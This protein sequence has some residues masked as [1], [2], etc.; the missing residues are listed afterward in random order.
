MIATCG[1]SLPAEPRQPFSY[2]VFVWRVVLFVV[3]L[4]L[5]VWVLA[6]WSIDQSRQL[7]QERAETTTK[8]LAHVLENN[9]A[10]A[11][12]K[13]DIALL[14]VVDEAERQLAAGG[15]DASALNGLLDR[16]LSRLPEVISLR[17]TNGRGDVLYGNAVAGT[18]V[19]LADREFFI[20]QR[21]HADSGLVISPP[22]L[23]R[24][25]QQ[26]VIPISRR[27]H[28]PD[29]SFAGVVYSNVS[30]AYL[31]RIFSALMVGQ[32]GVIAMRDADLGIVLRYPAI[33]DYGKMVGSKEVSSVFQKLAQSGQTAGTYTVV[34]GYDGVERTFSYRRLTSHPYYVVIGLATDEYLLGWWQQTV[35]WLIHLGLFLVITL[36]AAWLLYRAWERQAVYHANLCLEVEK[37]IHSEQ[38]LQTLNKELDQRVVAQTLELRA[39]NN[40]LQSASYAAAHNLRTPLRAVNGFAGSLLEDCATLLPAEG[41]ESLRLVVTSARE[42]EETVEGFLR[43]VRATSAGISRQRV[44]LS[45]L[46]HVV[47]DRLQA[48]DPQRH[49]ILEIASA[50][51]V[52]GDP[53]L[54]QT[55]MAVL[56]DNAW[57]F[58]RDSHPPRI[59]FFASMEQD[60]IVY[61]VRDNGVGFD[62]R[63]AERLFQPFQ[64]AHRAAE[65]PG[66]AV[67]LA[68]AQRIIARHGGKIWAESE[69]GRGAVFK[70][71]ILNQENLDAR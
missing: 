46:A 8:N 52:Q 18:K 35:T 3:S 47:L 7:Y 14:A 66:V 56:L 43:L 67:G 57:K 6:W 59:D 58:A 20:R 16:Q 33:E 50:L 69:P 34:S 68:I 21:D 64:R 25:S 36:I 22:L 29:G 31:A 60:Q 17:V 71:T 42:M 12:D 55:V 54:L 30:L 13:I 27:I 10:G 61:C 5:F 41:Q 40:E 19:N 2:K 70:F 45:A 9:L 39:A 24:I 37:R 15:I 23:A 62:M 4:N 51:T 53:Q 26:W 48:E 32:R 11:L 49:A 38:A 1:S 63:H 44:D 28:G 65:F